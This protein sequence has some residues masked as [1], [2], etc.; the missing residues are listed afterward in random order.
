MKKKD[1]DIYIPELDLFKKPSEQPQSEYIM[2]AIEKRL[3]T[4]VDDAYRAYANAVDRYRVLHRLIEA[5]REA[6]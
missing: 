5:Y 1:D 3:L 2:Q 6:I 4:E